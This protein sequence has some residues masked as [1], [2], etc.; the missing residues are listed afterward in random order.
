MVREFLKKYQLISFFILTYISSWLLMLPYMLTRNEQAFGIFIIIGIFFPA[1]VNILLSSI[2]S[3]SR[4]YNY[5]SKRRMTFFITWIIATVIFTFNVKTSSEIDSP[6]AIVFYAIVALLPA[7][8]LSSVF[9]KYSEVRKSLSSLLKPKGKAGWYIFALLVI[10]FIRIISIPLTR[11][12][13]LDPINEPSVHGSTAQVAVLVAVSFFYGIVFTGGLNEET[14]W[15]GFAL[16]RLQA[17]FSPLLSSII[18]WFFWILW[19]MPMQIAGLWNSNLDS[20]LRTLIGTFFARFIFTWL[21]NKTKGGILPAMLFHASANVCFVFLPENY[22]HMALEAV[23]AI[24]ILVIG[25]MWR[26]LS[27]KYPA[28]Y[29]KELET[30]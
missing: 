18:L 17:R 11:I 29:G 10:P 4:S 21:F 19:H 24:A 22:I 9:S 25:G 2:I 20:F 8:V 5:S 14:G 16:P 7:F 13:G 27:E 23:L 6:A 15:T 12:A 26:K 28:V 3:H 1:L 30:E